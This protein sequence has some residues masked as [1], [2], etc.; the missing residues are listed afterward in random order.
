MDKKGKVIVDETFIVTEGIVHTVELDADIAAEKVEMASKGIL[1][2]GK[3]FTYI[4]VDAK[5]CLGLH[6]LI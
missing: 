2:E 4:Y 3:I 1:I 6:T 5:I